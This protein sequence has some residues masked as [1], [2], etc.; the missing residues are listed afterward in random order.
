MFDRYLSEDIKN[1]FFTGKVTILTGA[2]QVGKTTLAGSILASYP[3]KSILKLNCDDISD[4]N[5]LTDKNLHDLI[6]L[7]NRYDIIFIDEA[8]KVTTIGDTLKLLVDHYKDAKHVFATGS[9]SFHLLNLTSEPLTGRKRTFQLYPLSSREIFHDGSFLDADKSLE[10][11]LRFGHYPDIANHTAIEDKTALLKELTTSTLYKDILEF[12]Y[13]KNA[14][15]LHDLLKALALQVGS[16]V[17][18]TE[19]AS[20]LSID[21]NTVERYIDLL[22]KSYVIFRLPPYYTNKRKEISKSKKIYFFDNGI[23]NAI[24]GNFAPLDMRGD[25]GALWENHLIV[26]RMKLQKVKLDDYHQYFWRSYNQA[27]IDYLEEES[28]KLSAFEFKWSSRK[29]RK[30]PPRAFAK[31]YPDATFET[32]T[33]E[34]YHNFIGLT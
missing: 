30:K 21:K 9:S 34:N 6:A 14:H 2:R 3:E 28:L 22:E 18:Y 20:L 15:V 32:I 5:L 19:L 17:S 16:E 29:A 1:T 12:Q 11:S 26:E 10:V 7:C 23:R 13:V 8:Q 4:R 24:I 25:V 31:A 33:P 27:E